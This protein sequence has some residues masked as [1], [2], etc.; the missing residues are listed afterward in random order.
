M[1]TNIA[2][3]THEMRACA[4]GPQPLNWVVNCYTHD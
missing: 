3:E 4:L 1:T 2:F